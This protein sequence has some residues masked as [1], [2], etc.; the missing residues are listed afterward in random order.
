MDDSAGPANLSAPANTPA[1]ADEN[2]VQRI[3]ICYTHSAMAEVAQFHELLENRLRVRSRAYTVFRDK[4][5]RTERILGGDDYR[6]IVKTKLADAICC[7]VILVPDIFFS[8][9]CEREV[10]T[11]QARIDRGDRCFFFPVEFVSVRSDFKE[12]SPQHNRISQILR[13]IDRV[14]FTRLWEAEKSN[15]EYRRAVDEI[16][17]AIDLQ[18]QR[19]REK[20][21]TAA[22]VAHAV[23]RRAKIGLVTIG[24]LLFIAAALMVVPQTRIPIAAELS[25]LF[26]NEESTPPTVNWAAQEDT[27]DLA[28]PVSYFEVPPPWSE[29]AEPAGILQPGVLRA[30][31]NGVESINSASIDGV[32]YY[33]IERERAEPA[34]LSSDVVPAWDDGPATLDLVLPTPTYA[35]PDMNEEPVQELQPGLISKADADVAAI[36]VG[37]VDGTLWYR[38]EDSDGAR[39]YIQAAS[40]AE[41][42]QLPDGIDAIA[43]IEVR[44]RPDSALAASGMFLPGEQF[45]APRQATIDGVSWFRFTTLSGDVFFEEAEGAG[46]LAVWK[47]EIGCLV[48]AADGRA[49]TAPD[50]NA[51]SYG[52]VVEAVPLSR[53]RPVQSAEVGGDRWYRYRDDS[54]PVP[55]YGYVEAALVRLDAC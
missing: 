11:F 16:A 17:D 27:I 9:E 2:G 3:F 12:P 18:V 53:G 5:S 22:S 15:P 1:P 24:A 55:E 33:R 47:D 19:R 38:I 23:R 46:K 4:G 34:Y 36:L 32:D 21:S 6:E 30:G 51:G 40:I 41:W 31:M 50:R 14:D 43:P 42:T 10:K 44:S 52:S 29:E 8:V 7:L 20:A 13:F 37:S 48:G 28:L 45:S 39:R 35:I 26:G 54:G 49:H 25:A